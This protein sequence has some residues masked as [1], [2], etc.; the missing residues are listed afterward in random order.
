MAKRV[1]PERVTYIPPE[2]L[3]RDAVRER[4]AELMEKDASPEEIIAAMQD[5][6]GGRGE[7]RE[8]LDPKVHELKLPGRDPIP[9]VE[10]QVLGQLVVWVDEA[11]GYGSDLIIEDHPL[12]ADEG[13][14]TGA[15]VNADGDEH[16]K[17]LSSGAGH[18]EIFDGDEAEYE[19]QRVKA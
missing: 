8:V 9:M 18:F 6:G 17:G 4:V 7:Y 1:E 15:G 12:S 14:V 2:F 10:E 11:P 19:P 3:N 5:A 13:A 16:P